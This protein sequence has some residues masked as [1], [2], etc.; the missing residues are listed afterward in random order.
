MFL[1]TAYRIIKFSLQN[2]FRNIWLSIVTVTII[3]MSLFV[4]TM[5][6]AL[7]V[8]VQDTVTNLQE[9][10][11]ISVY[12]KPDIKQSDIK[13]IQDNLNKL[14]IVKETTYIDKDTALEN[15]KKKYENNQIILKSLDALGKNPL[16]DILVIKAKDINDY[17]QILQILQQE[18]L[19]Q[20]IQDSDF[21]DYEKIIAKISQVSKKVNQIGVVVSLVFIAIAILVMFNTIRMAI[22]TQREEIAIMRLVGAS[23]AFIRTPFLLEGFFYALIAVFINILVLFPILGAVQPFIGS[24]FGAE[25][26]DLAQYFKTHFVQ[27]FGFE[28]L[29]ILILNTISSWIA[30]R[31][32]IKL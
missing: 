14:K 24:F 30:I 7:N 28:F 26:L 21:S 32:Y 16:S 13:T 18:E 31:K 19:K 9:K 15:F 17:E 20:Y 12:F 22:Y 29:L 1:I 10:V 6:V 27:V 11:D 2:F 3:V 4:M 5:L 25:T 23:S 8:V